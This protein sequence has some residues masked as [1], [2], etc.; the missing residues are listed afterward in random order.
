MTRSLGA[1]VGWGLSRLA[2]L[3]GR[4]SIYYVIDDADWSIY[5]DGRY[6]T[7]GLRDRHG[8]KTEIVRRTG[9]IRGQII[10]FGSRYS[11][12][13]GSC[14]SL[15]L[16]NRIFLTWFHGNPTD[17]DF[18]KLF[19]A[20]GRV[21]GVAEKIVVPCTLTKAPLLDMGLPPEQLVTIPLGVELGRFR[22]ATSAEKEI[23]RDDLGIA[24]GAVVV[25]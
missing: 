18:T 22:P 9:G 21:A 14:G 2:A 24:D 4:A 6:I 17:P 3:G 8:W 11:F 20:L 5:W 13:D 1:R 25:G 23:I 19:D 12:L 7:E 15:Y 16:F 10:Q